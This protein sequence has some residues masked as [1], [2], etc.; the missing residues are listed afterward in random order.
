MLM[1]IIKTK[2]I[3]IIKI[4]PSRTII[5]VIK[6]I[7]NRTMKTDILHGEEN[8]IKR[9]R[10]KGDMEKVASQEVDIREGQ[11]EVIKEGVMKEAQEETA[12]VM[13]EVVELLPPT[14]E[15][16]LLVGSSCRI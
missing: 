2:S 14:P 7:E 15:H 11:T 3:I 1:A 16:V 12:I 8:T 5:M 10:I 4:M 13:V 9:E 6:T